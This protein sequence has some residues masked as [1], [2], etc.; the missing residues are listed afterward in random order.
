MKKVQSKIIQ[1]SARIKYCLATASFLATPEILAANAALDKKIEN[2]TPADSVMPM[3]LGLVAVL[4]IIVLLALLLK[5]VTGLNLAS[6][7]IKLID[8]TRLGTKE[9]LVI[10]EIQQ[11]QYVLGVTAHSINTVCELQQPIVK[12]APSMS[13]DKM[14]KQ[15]LQPPQAKTNQTQKSPSPDIGEK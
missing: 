14:M 5:K 6:S 10:V 9:K 13:F 15:F 2:L 8:S 12:K 1:T 11:Q 7:H 3:L 4:V